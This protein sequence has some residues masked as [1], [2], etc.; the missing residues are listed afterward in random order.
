MERERDRIRTHQEW[1]MDVVLPVKDAQI[2]M[3]ACCKEVEDEGQSMNPT[4]TARVVLLRFS[5]SLRGTA[6]GM[7]DR[8]RTW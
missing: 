6:A 3:C 7:T 1:R 8:A 5:S 4:T 2:F